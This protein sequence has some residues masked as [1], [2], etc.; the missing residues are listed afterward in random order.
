MLVAANPAVTAQGAEI[1]AFDGYVDTVKVVRFQ[2]LVEEVERTKEESGAEE[3]AAFTVIRVGNCTNLSIDAE[4]GFVA[5]NRVLSYIKL[6][7]DAQLP[8]LKLAVKNWNK[9]PVST[10]IRAKLL[11]RNRGVDQFTRTEDGV[12]HFFEHPIQILANVEVGAGTRTWLVS[13]AAFAMSYHEI[14]KTHALV[15]RDFARIDEHLDSLEARIRVLHN[16]ASAEILV[17]AALAAVP[18]PY[19]D[20]DLRPVAFETLN[21]L[22]LLARC[23]YAVLRNIKKRSGDGGRS[24]AAAGVG[25]DSD[26][27]KRKSQRAGGSTSGDVVTCDITASQLKFLE[28]VAV[29]NGDLWA[30]TSAHAYP[31]GDDRSGV[32]V[33]LPSGHM[34]AVTG[35]AGTKVQAL[36]RD[37]TQASQMESL[38]PYMFYQLSGF[39]GDINHLAVME[40][41]KR[42]KKPMVAPTKAD[43]ESAKAAITLFALRLTNAM[44][45]SPVLF[46][47]MHASAEKT[48][49]RKSRSVEKVASS[50]PLPP[51]PAPVKSRPATIKVPPVVI[52]KR[53]ATPRM[54]VPTLPEEE[55]DEET[56]E[57]E[58]TEEAEIAE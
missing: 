19:T 9:T 25:S 1:N 6:V 53:L 26:D 22:A 44:I 50:A 58:E 46:D 4:T 11:L 21:R 36:L 7:C 52:E 42:G 16:P 57:T 10:A 23:D 20:T 45:V 34:Y 5:M 12:T 28:G 14:T 51:P 43:V 49:R 29:E 33:V 54:A 2:P 48:A 41:V 38:L 27:D 35:A 31:L 40:S 30:E 18:V 15:G 55:E 39:D 47:L 13:A 17:N 37:R 3:K 32:I 24:G 56:E 8:A